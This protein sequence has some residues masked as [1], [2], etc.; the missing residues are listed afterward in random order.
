MVITSP[1]GQCEREHAI[2]PELDDPSFVMDGGVVPNAH[3]QQILEVG[4]TTVAPP[5]DVVD[6]AVV[7]AGRAVGNRAPGVDR[8]QRSS[9]RDV[10]EPR[11]AAEVETAGR[12]DDRSV[13]HDDGVHV[14]VAAPGR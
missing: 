8:S 7:E 6:L 11:G 14:G 1:F 9:L 4:A 13:A 2:G 5:V 10:R 3:G 12:V